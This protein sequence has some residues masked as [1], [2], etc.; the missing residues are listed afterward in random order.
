MLFALDEKTSVEN[1]FLVLIT[2]SAQ[3]I[4]VIK[5]DL[6]PD[7]VPTRIDEKSKHQLPHLLKI[8]AI[9]TPKLKVIWF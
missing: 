3:V 7:I 8:L 2:A 4:Q 6:S 1:V 9:W 5:V